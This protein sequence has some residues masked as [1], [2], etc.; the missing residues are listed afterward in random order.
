MAALLDVRRNNRQSVPCTQELRDKGASKLLAGLY[1]SADRQ[2]IGYTIRLLAASVA[3]PTKQALCG[4]GKL[5][6]VQYLLNTINYA[7]SICIGP[8]GAS[9]LMSSL[10]VSCSSS[11]EHLLE[12]YSDSDWSGSRK[13]DRLSV[14]GG[15]FVLDS[16]YTRATRADPE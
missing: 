13:E 11:G 10:N 15:S 7:T 16:C 5:E 3:S 9:K 8:P 14:G 12:C 2:D 4:L 1:K 6:L